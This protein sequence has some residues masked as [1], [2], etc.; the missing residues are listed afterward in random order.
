M[1]VLCWMYI[2]RILH[3][4]VAFLRIVLFLST[5]ILDTV[6]DFLIKMGIK[7]SMHLLEISIFSNKWC[8]SQ[9]YQKYEQH[10]Q[11]LQ[12]SDFQSLVPASKINQIFLIFFSMK[13]IRLGLQLLHII[14]L[15]NLI[16]KVLY[17]LKICPIFVGSYLY[18][19]R[20][21]D[22]II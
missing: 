18:F 16:F 7:P 5:Y 12:N 22:D 1:C 14:F 11:R 8:H 13:N 6:T 19:G 2:L 9:T 17:V 4:I 20:S 15:K 3:Q 10:P 21:K